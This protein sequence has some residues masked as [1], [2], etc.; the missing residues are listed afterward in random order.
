MSLE[1]AQIL[2]KEL[3]SP[4][5]VMI[6]DDSPVTRGFLIRLLS[7][8]NSIKVVGYARN[9]QDA[10]DKIRIIKPDIVLLDVEM[11]IM[12][13][14][15]ALPK[16]LEQYPDANVI[17]VSS[18]TSSNTKTT[19][20]ALSKGAADCI[21]KPTSSSDNSEFANKLTSKIKEITTTERSKKIARLREEAEHS[22]LEPSKSS[23]NNSSLESGKIEITHHKKCKDEIVLDTYIHHKISKGEIS[24]KQGDIVVPKALAIGASTG[25][26]QALASL[27]ENLN[28]PLDS[29]PIFITLHMPEQ[30]TSFVV[31]RINQVSKQKCFEAKDGMEVEPGNI[32]LA[33]GHSHMLVKKSSNKTVISLDK[34]EPINFCI[35]SVD[36]MFSS[37]SDCYSGKVLGVMLTGMGQDGLNGSRYIVD[38]G[39]AIIAQDEQS[40]VVWGMP[41]AVAKNGLCSYI[42]PITELADCILRVCK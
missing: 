5:Q 36:P 33:P 2:E 19:L 11:P 28:E 10:I 8:D 31:Q 25:G 41:G 12:D 39:G 6:V 30:F 4:Y 7:E 40:S 42:A 17:M 37:L 27:F 15:T 29:I 24:L 26:P 13:G 38:K 35:P 21:E 1:L 20:D 3:D 14:L 23:N 34:G 16:I 9:G 18:L 32:Y 22:K